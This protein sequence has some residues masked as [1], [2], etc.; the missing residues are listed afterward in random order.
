MF[1]DNCKA[2]PVNLSFSNI[3]IIFLPAN[4]TSVLQ[5]LDAGIIKCFKGYYR[6]HMARF[7][8]K[9]VKDN[10]YGGIL[11]LNAVKFYQA[12][13]MAVESWSDVKQ[14]YLTVLDI[15]VFIN[16]F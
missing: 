16:R 8:I 15:V 1:I 14:L 4:T 13:E 5:P 12:V 2:H 9:W 11:R 10:Q 6:T 3:K 7:L